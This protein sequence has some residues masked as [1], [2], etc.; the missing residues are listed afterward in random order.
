MDATDQRSVLPDAGWKISPIECP[1]KTSPKP[2][3]KL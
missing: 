1:H 3:Q 2:A